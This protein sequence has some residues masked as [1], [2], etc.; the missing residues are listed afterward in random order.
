MTERKLCKC[1]FETS[2]GLALTSP[3]QEET[4]GSATTLAGQESQ[5]GLPPPSAHGARETQT[6][7]SQFGGHESCRSSL[8][9]GGEKWAGPA[10]SP[11]LWALNS[12]DTLTGGSTQRDWKRE[13]LVL[14]PGVRGTPPT[15]H[16]TLPEVPAE[17]T[18]HPCE[19]R[20]TRSSPAALEERRRSWGLLG[21][22]TWPA[23]CEATSQQQTARL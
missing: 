4:G 1:P 8:R 18:G 19:N 14:L 5:P 2:G 23:L 12:S 21:R 10:R 20:K 17:P 6:V 3:K 7:E 22:P 15:R 9:G 13:C 11:R 16:I